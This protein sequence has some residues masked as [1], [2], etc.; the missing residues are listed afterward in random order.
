VELTN[1]YG[2]RQK[3]YVT[4]NI[5]F[6]R[7]SGASG[8]NYV[9]HLNTASSSMTSTNWFLD[10]NC[11][12]SFNRSGKFIY[13]PSGFGQMS[14][15]NMRSAGF[16]IH[17]LFADPLFTSISSG[18]TDPL[19][20]NLMPLAGSPVINAGAPMAGFSND[21]MGTSRPQGSAWDIGAH[22][23]AGGGQPPEPPDRLRVTST[24]P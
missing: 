7:N 23:S 6:D 3:V 14:L 8:N 20:M 10:Y 12:M 24:E 16:E 21:R 18:F 2:D 17:G 11:Y 19:N 4:N 13:S 15:A 5:F 9:I 22:E 1:P